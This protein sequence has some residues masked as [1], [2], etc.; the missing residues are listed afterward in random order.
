MRGIVIEAWA[1]FLVNQLASGLFFEQGLK[2]LLL[3]ATA[4]AVAG[5]LIKPIINILLLPINL[6]TFNFF[7][8]ASH[9]VM[10][11]LVDLVLTEFRIVNFNF[12]GYSSDLFS[13]PLL[14][15]ESGILSYLAFSV[16]IGLVAGVFYW[17]M[18][19]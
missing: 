19:K 13:L 14:Y 15:I 3:T 11:F 5:L 6:V 4:L 7:R 16:L 2:S 9:A 12:A 10:L 8:W 18:E 17:I 1:L